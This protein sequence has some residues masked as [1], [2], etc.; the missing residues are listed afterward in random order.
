LSKHF[1]EMTENLQSEI[2]QKVHK[3]ILYSVYVMYVYL[4]VSFC[5]SI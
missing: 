3:S 2:L 4:Y 1:T 5:L